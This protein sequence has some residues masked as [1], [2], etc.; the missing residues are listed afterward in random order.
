LLTR[1]RD[2]GRRFIVPA[3]EKLSAFMELESAIGA[4]GKSS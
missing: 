3:D 2:D 1:T 4:C